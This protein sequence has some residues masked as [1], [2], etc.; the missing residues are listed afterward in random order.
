MDQFNYKRATHIYKS[1]N[2]LDL[3][4]ILEILTCG[5]K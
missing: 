5:R 3:G 4:A 2:K 1:E